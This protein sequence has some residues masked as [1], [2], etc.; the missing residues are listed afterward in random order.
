MVGLGQRWRIYMRYRSMM[1]NDATSSMMSATRP[2][3]RPSVNIDKGISQLVQTQFSVCFPRFSDPQIVHNTLS[4]HQLMLVSW[5]EGRQASDE[6]TTFIEKRLDPPRM[7]RRQDDIRENEQPSFS[8]ISARGAKCAATEDKQESALC[9][10]QHNELAGNNNNNN[11][12]KRTISQKN[13]AA[14]VGRDR[15]A[16]HINNLCWRHLQNQNGNS[17]QS[18]RKIQMTQDDQG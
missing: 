11:S 1:M 5:V 8:N 13:V 18:S 4:N 14:Q 7:T 15:K 2:S 16:A 6:R 9:V 12:G 17:Q 3:V 10:Q